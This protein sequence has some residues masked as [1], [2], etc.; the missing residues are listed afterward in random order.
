VLFVDHANTRSP[1]GLVPIIF[2]CLATAYVATTVAY[3]Y[4]T[5]PVNRH[6]AAAFFGFAP[7]QP[8]TLR[9]R[10]C[11]HSRFLTCRALHGVSSSAR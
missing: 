5:D 4:D 9:G 6:R 8:W 3:N 7:T 10:A 1:M 11:V 2:A